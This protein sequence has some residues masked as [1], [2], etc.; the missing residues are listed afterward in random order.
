VGGTPVANDDFGAPIVIGA[1]P[2]TNTQDVAGATTAPDDPGFACV[3]G[4]KNKSVWY[5]YTPTN[6]APLIVNTV[7]SNYDTV[8]GVWTGSRGSLTSVACN[9]DGPGTGSQSQVQF[10]PTAGTTYYIEVAS[11]FPNPTAP[12]LVLNVTGPVLQEMSFRSLGSYDGWLLEQ[13]ETS[14]KG[15]SFDA[16]ATTARV[17]DDA[18]D[19]QY[20][21][22]L[23]FDTSALP[24]TAVITAVTLKIQ[25][26]SIVGGNPF[27][28]TH[29]TLTVDLK[30]GAYHENPALENVDFHAVGSR[31]NVGKFIKTPSLGWYRSPLRAPAYPLISLSGTTQFRLRFS[32]DDNDN[33]V[34]DYLS[35]YTGSTPA[36]TDRPELIVTYYVP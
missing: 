19:R 35:F 25:K 32:T 33:G 2:Y 12:Q 17:G 34:A 7:G 5:R 9:D 20:R 30:T 15:G 16:A 14:G 26:Q 27:L 28:G 31:G 23:H 29:G 21:S 36:L 10:I 18:L 3:T 8:L 22:L 4:P 13:D 1:V 24:D 11:Y 6:G